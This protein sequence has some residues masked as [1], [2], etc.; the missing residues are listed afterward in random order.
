M[1]NSDIK[2]TTNSL[3]QLHS[4]HDEPSFIFS[5]GMKEWHKNN[6][7]HREIGP[8]VTYLGKQLWYWEDEEIR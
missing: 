5:S 2:F 8:A 7:L 6:S 1:G 3:K 4:F